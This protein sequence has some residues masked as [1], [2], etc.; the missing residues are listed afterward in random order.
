ME[1]TH[2]ITI[3]GLGKSGYAAAS[4]MAARGKKVMVSEYGQLKGENLALAQELEQ[5]GIE[6]ESGGHSDKALEQADLIIT[7]PGIAPDTA[8]IKKA[9]ALGKEVISDIELAY[10]EGKTPIIAITGTNGKSTTTALISHILQSNDLIAPACGNIGLPVLDYLPSNQ[11]Q[12]SNGNKLT[13]TPRYLVMEVSS[14]QLFYTKQFAPYISVWMNLTPDHLEWHKNMDAYISAKDNIFAH[15]DKFDIA[16]LK[17]PKAQKQP[18]AVLNYDDP[19][20]KAR[21]VKAEIFP[22]SCQNNLKD[23]ASAAFVENNWLKYRFKGKVESV[24]SVDE[25]PIIGQ[26]NVENALAAIA[27]SVICGLSAKQISQAIKNSKP[28]NI[29]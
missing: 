18:Y 27:V 22:F 24:C 7:S 23:H 14:Y 2:N 25:M 11:T 12:S 9:Y 13:S 1:S 21:K 26:H 8:V 29:V 4:Y 20:V 5:M 19:I 3:L 15:Q 17:D 28:L 16:H 10:K 6:I